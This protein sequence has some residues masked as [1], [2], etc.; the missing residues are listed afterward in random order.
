[1]GHPIILKEIIVTHS[2]RR[3]RWCF[4]ISIKKVKGPSLHQTSIY[5]YLYKDEKL[6]EDYLLELDKLMQ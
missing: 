3:N 2:C 5:P 4:A 1:M 6:S